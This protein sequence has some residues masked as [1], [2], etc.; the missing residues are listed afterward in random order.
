MNTRFAGF[1]IWSAPPKLQ[2]L[3]QIKY[4][5]HS[6]VIK[7]SMTLKHSERYKNFTLNFLACSQKDSKILFRWNGLPVGT[8]LYSQTFS[9]G[10]CFVF[11]PNH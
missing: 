7:Q 8:P 4:L 6:G 3:A 11:L 1:F 2:A 5:P 9:A 10:D